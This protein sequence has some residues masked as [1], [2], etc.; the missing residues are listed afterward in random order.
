M[1]VEAIYDTSDLRPN[2][3]LG[4]LIDET[5]MTGL[6]NAYPVAGG[7][8]MPFTALDIY[9]NNNRTLTVYV[10]TADLNIVDITSAVAILTVKVSKE[11]TSPDIV[12]STA[13]AG[14]GAIG[15]A[16][17]GELY[18]YLVPADTVNMAIRQY[19]YDVTITLAT[20]KKYTVLEGVIN[21]IAP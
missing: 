16:N 6:V 8:A 5:K 12:K 4:I 18:F 14:Q 2:D 7:C 20:G 10:K 11:S 17:K 13:I 15:A 21:L 9:A 19:V 3:L 1:G